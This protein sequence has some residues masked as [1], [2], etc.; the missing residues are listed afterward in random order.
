MLWIY[1]YPYQGQVV[2]NEKPWR[3]PDVGRSKMWFSGLENVVELKITS[4]AI[5]KAKKQVDD[6]AHVH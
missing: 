5:D 4:A 6:G 3:L 2:T 1:S